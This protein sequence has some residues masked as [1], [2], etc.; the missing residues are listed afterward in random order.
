M[1]VRWGKGGGGVAITSMRKTH[2]KYNEQRELKV[3]INYT[4]HTYM[5][6][7]SDARNN[8]EAFALCERETE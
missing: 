3:F 7:K 8:A 1:A 2:C 4:K 6:N 5:T